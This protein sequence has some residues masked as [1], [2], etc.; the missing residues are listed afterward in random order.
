MAGQ[1]F[2]R[3]GRRLYLTGSERR[4]FLAATIQ[5]PREVRTFCG[6]LTHTGCRISEGLVLTVDGV[7]LEAGVLIFETLKQRRRGVYRAVPV[8]PALLEALDLVH[9]IRE[10]Q[11]TKGQS[12]RRRLW[13]WSR[14]TAWAWVRRVMQAAQLAGPQAMPKG[15]RHGFG[16]A[17]VEAKIPVNLIQRWMGHAQLSTTVRYLDAIDAEERSLATRMWEPLLG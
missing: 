1:L 16:I 17:A 2:N 3:G 10:V 12:H 6:V 15:L 13:P 8:P 9:G 5:Y 7:D 14:T 4:A 11:Q